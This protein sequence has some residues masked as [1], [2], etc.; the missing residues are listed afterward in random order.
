M[1]RIIRTL[2]LCARSGLTSN[3]PAEANR[4]SDCRFT[5]FVALRYFNF[6][7]RT[8]VLLGREVGSDILT[9]TNWKLAQKCL[10]P[11]LF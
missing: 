5:T 7:G 2:L 10:I 9:G 8:D 6:V 1:Y 11:D 4:W 3:P